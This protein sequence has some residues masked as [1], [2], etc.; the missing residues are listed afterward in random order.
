M[1]CSRGS[2]PPGERFSTKCLH[3]AFRSL[4]LLGKE[5]ARSLSASDAFGSEMVILTISA[6]VGLSEVDAE[7][8]FGA[9]AFIRINTWEG[10]G[11]SRCTEGD[12][13][14]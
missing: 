3:G 5:G 9:Q 6:R 4:S 12:V 13:G 1:W 14:L 8:E 2:P 11:G 10:C 7:M